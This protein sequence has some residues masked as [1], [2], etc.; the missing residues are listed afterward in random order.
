MEESMRFWIVSTLGL[1]LVG[2]IALAQVPVGAQFQVNSYTAFFQ[3]EPAVA[4]DAQGNFVV[5]WETYGSYGTETNSESVEGQ[6]YDASG[7]PVGGQFQVNSYT[8]SFQGRPGV[9][10]DPRGNFVVVWASFG[11]YGTDSSSY[12]IPAQR[13]DAN[14]TPMGGEFQVNSYTTSDQTRP[15]VAADADG[16]FVVVWDSAGSYGTDTSSWS[17]Q[18][19]RY[20]DGTPVGGQ[21]QVNSY[22][23]SHQSLYGPA[24]ALDTQGNFVV[25]WQSYGSYGTDTSHSS[26]QG[27]RYDANGTPMGG[28]F[29]VNSYTTSF[30]GRPGVAADPRGNFV[31]VWDSWGS[32]GTDTSYSSIQG[33]RYDA[34]GTPVG[35]QFQVNSYTTSFQRRPGVAAD[36]RGNFVVVWDSRG[37]YGTDTSTTSVQARLYDASGTPAGGQFQVNSYTTSSQYKAAVAA[38]GQGDFVV[39]WQGWGSYGSDNDTWSIQGQRYSTGGIFDSDGDGVPDDLDVCADTVIPEGVPTKRL[40]RNRFALVDGDGVFD[41]NRPPGRGPGD[42]FTIEETAGCSCE[43][44]IDALG[45]GKGHVKFGCSIGAMKAWVSMVNP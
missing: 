40:G 20:Y 39:V 41:T 12:S 34:S 22:T 45:L 23:R 1:L 18:A 25:V 42:S 11:S 31:V 35:G 44:I 26:I 13:Y 10:A 17:I 8:T 19:Q 36:P 3:W 38:D 9:A 29:Q 4:V 15:S 30:Q 28:E 24:V 6:R 43:Q 27:Q 32:Y 37:S 5:V 33:Q 21:F 7:T 16:N 2:G 14:G